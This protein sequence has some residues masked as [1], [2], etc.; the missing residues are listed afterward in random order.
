MNSTATTISI[1]LRHIVPALQAIQRDLEAERAAPPRESPPK[2]AP[3]A[4]SKKLLNTKEA[5]EYLGVSV[6]T[7]YKLSAG[8]QLPHYKVGSRTLFREEQLLDW[9]A[10]H[11]RTSVEHLP[12]HRGSR[13]N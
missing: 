4:P 13:R 2:Q 11:E 10:S 6:F 5:A 7:I 12:P 9:L 8:G 1:I 3:P